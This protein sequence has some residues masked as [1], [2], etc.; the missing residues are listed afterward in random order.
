ME[1]NEI[2]NWIV[3]VILSGLV[4]NGYGY[5]DNW[6]NSNNKK[7]LIVIFYFDKQF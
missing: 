1:N 6:H 5:H 4:A 3:N 7:G 2:K